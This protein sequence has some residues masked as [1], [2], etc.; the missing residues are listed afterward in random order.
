MSYTQLG[1]TLVVILLKMKNSMLLLITTF[2]MI[3]LLTSFTPET[4]WT[5]EGAR[6][7]TSQVEAIGRSSRGWV[8][9]SG[10]NRPPAA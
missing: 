10:R 9:G 1:D 5:Q 7:P 3:L 2:S 4:A 6:S 8:I